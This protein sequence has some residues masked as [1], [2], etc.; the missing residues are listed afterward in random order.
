[1]FKLQYSYHILCAGLILL[2]L[3]CKNQVLHEEANYT[4]E[5]TMLE[6][7]KDVEILYSDS[8]I[9]RVRV[10]APLLHNYSDRAT[11]RQ[12]FPQGIKVEFLNAF[13][14]VEN[15]LTS[16]TAVRD[17][18]KGVVIAR[19]SV[20][21]ITAKQEKLETEELTWDEKTAKIR[22]EKFVKV[23][24]PGEVIYGFGLEAEQDFSYWKI[25]V[26]KGKIKAEQVD[27]V[28]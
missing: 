10:T 13:Q 24:K 23:S 21:M 7:G 12:E 20:V 11:P 1:M 28:K 17:Q 5:D 25:L 4:T 6:V 19:D 15:T 2:A 26:P 8:A 14:K 9:V 18:D 27:D 22:T 3:A 16:K